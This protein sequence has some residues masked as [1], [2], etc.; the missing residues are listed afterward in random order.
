MYTLEIAIVLGSFLFVSIVTLI[1]LSIRVLRLK[2]NIKKL[3]V[4]YSKVTQLMLSNNKLD[5]NVHQESFIKFLSDSRDSAFEYI[6]E[7]QAGIT[8]FVEDVDAEIS[9]FDEYGDVMAMQPNYQSMK[10]IS[11]A[12]KKLKKLLPE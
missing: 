6:E 10:K 8:N 12:Y 5:N 1:V 3:S 9:Y 7:V 2:N 11:M 4:A